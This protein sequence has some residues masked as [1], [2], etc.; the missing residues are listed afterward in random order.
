MVALLASLEVVQHEE[1]TSAE[2]RMIVVRKVVPRRRAA[3]GSRLDR[4]TKRDEAKGEDAPKRDGECVL[5]KRLLRF[6]LVAHWGR[7][8]QRVGRPVGDRHVLSLLGVVVLAADDLNQ[9]GRRIERRISLEPYYRRMQGKEETDLD[10]AVKERRLGR[11]LLN[12]E[13]W[14]PP[15]DLE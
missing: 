15:L 1:S 6:A 12:P 3:E 5:A 2:A 13:R 4:R 14:P 9:Q 8:E 11:D 7:L 10:D